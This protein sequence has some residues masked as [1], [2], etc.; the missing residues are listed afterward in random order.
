MA[1]ATTWHDRT[2]GLLRIV[3]A[4]IFLLHGTIKALHWPAPQPELLAML[5]P[6]SLMWWSGI[7]EVIM[8]PLLLLGL[9]T[10]PVAFLASGEM[11]VGYF[12]IHAPLSFWPAQNDGDAAILYT[13]VFLYIAIAG[14]GAF[15]LDH[16]IPWRRLLRRDA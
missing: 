12:A 4:L 15:A 9:A 5:T 2:L 14:P 3:T 8:G 1:Q 10:R 16:L 7:L 13:F 6:G 11:A